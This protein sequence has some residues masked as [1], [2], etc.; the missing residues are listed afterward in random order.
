MSTP[1]HRFSGSRSLG[2]SVAA[3]SFTNIT[4]RKLTPAPPPTSYNSHPL[5]PVYIRPILPKPDTMFAAAP[6]PP[7][8]PPPPQAPTLKCQSSRLLE[9]PEL[10]D[11]NVSSSASPPTSLRR[12]WSTGE[13]SPLF[14]HRQAPT[15][16][17]RP[18]RWTWT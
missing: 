7:P 6:P 5:S 4:L 13:L 14:H 2:H 11:C 10:S 17:P 12:R 18:H 8:P 3:L 9:D 15:T 16:P 1:E